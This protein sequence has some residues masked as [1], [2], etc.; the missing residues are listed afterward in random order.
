[1][2]FW[3]YLNL[4]KMDFGKKKIREIDLFDFTSFFVLNYFKFSGLLCLVS[5]VVT[6]ISSYDRLT[7]G[8]LAI[9]M[10]QLR[11]PRLQR[12]RLAFFKQKSYL[13]TVTRDQITFGW[14]LWGP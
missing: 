3:P 10:L 8:L 13:S 12:G 11:M 4:Q 5:H 6:I 7:S 9:T 14:P 2:D 1:M